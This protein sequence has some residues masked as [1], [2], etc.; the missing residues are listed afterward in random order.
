MEKREPIFRIML[1][2]FWHPCPSKYMNA[3][4]IYGNTDI[5][6]YY[7]TTD[8]YV[9]KDRTLVDQACRGLLPMSCL[10]KEINDK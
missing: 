4:P 6:T 8:V 3:R 1:C 10:S 2:N 7:A 9:F 5:S